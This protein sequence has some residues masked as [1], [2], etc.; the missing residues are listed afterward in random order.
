MKAFMAQ[1]SNFLAKPPSAS[2]CHQYPA[3]RNGGDE[4]D[5]GDE[6]HESHEG[7]E[8]NEG[9]KGRSEI[10]G[11]R[12]HP[13]ED[14]W[15]RQEAGGQGALCQGQGNP[16]GEVEAMN[17]DLAVGAA[18]LCRDSRVVVLPRPGCPSCKFPFGSPKKKK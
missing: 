14:D 11:L 3:T 6:G 18:G 7:H 17:M 16:R 13:G 2:A 1:G 8:G 10:A 5:E 9:K 12:G 4:G 15:R